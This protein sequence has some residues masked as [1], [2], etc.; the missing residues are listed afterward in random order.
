MWRRFEQKPCL[1]PAGECGVSVG[2]KGEMEERQTSY[3]SLGL[4]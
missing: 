1:V 2:R 3:S 4:N